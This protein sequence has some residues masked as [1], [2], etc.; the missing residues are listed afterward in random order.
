LDN[1][2][3]ILFFDKIINFYKGICENVAYNVNSEIVNFL[4]DLK[5]HSLL[6]GILGLIN[7]KKK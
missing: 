7:K 3:D 2:D 1:E 6:F 5:K 4:N